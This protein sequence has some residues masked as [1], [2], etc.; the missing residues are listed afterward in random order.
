MSGI[1]FTVDATKA[2]DAGD[3]YPGT[4]YAA[5]KSINRVSIQ[6][7]GGKAFDLKATYTIATN[8]F[9]AAGGDTYYVFA[10]ATSNVD[11]GCVMDEVV[12][13]YI[14]TKLGGVITADY[15][16]AKGRI[17]VLYPS[18]PPPPPGIPLPC[19]MSTPTRS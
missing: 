9:T 5:P 14:T 18:T 8:N 4:T 11:T 15:G 12:M 7:V 3:N 1:V 17:T 2:F 16:T 6:S 13:D 10:N 19:S